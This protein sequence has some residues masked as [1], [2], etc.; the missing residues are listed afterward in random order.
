VDCTVQTWVL[1]KTYGKAGST[2]E[3]GMYALV[4]RRTPKTFTITDKSFFEYDLLLIDESEPSVP[5]INIKG[6][7]VNEIPNVVRA[8]LFNEIQV[9]QPT[10]P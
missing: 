5:S 3:D 4:I 8:L 2:E 6:V 10:G 1:S 9:G 7:R